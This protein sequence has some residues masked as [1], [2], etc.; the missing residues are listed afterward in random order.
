[1]AAIAKTVPSKSF[2][3]SLSLRI[4]PITNAK[5][6]VPPVISG[7]CTD[8]GRNISAISAKRFPELFIIAY[9][10]QK[11]APFFVTL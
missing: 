6:I 7:Y 3:V 10:P 9:T 2:L 5:N 1:M 4:R 8:A 11:A